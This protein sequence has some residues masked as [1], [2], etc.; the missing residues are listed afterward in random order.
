MKMKYYPAIALFL[1]LAAC[2]NSD[3]EYDASGVFETDEV[4][5]S[6]RGTGELIQ[7]NL[8]EGQNVIAGEQLGYAKAATAGQHTSYR[9]PAL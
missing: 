2:G 3:R 8:E 6:A 9:K 7:F 1:L 4:I 5:V